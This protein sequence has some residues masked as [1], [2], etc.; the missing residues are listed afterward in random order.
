MSGIQT[1]RL[2]EHPLARGRAEAVCNFLTVLSVGNPL[3]LART[4]VGG[5]GGQHSGVDGGVRGSYF[6]GDKKENQ[7][8]T[9]SAGPWANTTEKNGNNTGEKTTCESAAETMA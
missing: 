3:V 7:S 5:G 9:L 4:G 6:S 2:G 1:E 8:A